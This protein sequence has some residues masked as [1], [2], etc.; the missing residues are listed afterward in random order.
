M[1]VSLEST[2]LCLPPH[3]LPHRRT[4]PRTDRP[5]QGALVGAQR[6]TCEHVAALC[7]RRRQTGCP[8]VWE[9][10][11][12]KSQCKWT[13]RGK[14]NQELTSENLGSWSSCPPFYP[15]KNGGD[16]AS[17]RPGGSARRGFCRNGRG[18]RRCGAFVPCSG[19]G[20]RTCG[21]ELGASSAARPS[22]N[23]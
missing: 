8:H 10:N 18:R 17:S 1:S 23:S 21:H 3:P 2:R 20:P 7:T 16:P 5:M 9:A 15:E 11:I 4:S 19:K 6:A 12:L 22:T 13:V 14:C